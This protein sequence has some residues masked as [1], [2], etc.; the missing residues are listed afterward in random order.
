MYSKIATIIS[1]SFLGAALEKMSNKKVLVSDS[2][3]TTG[4]KIIAGQRTMSCQ[5]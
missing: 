5:N 3:V 1:S 2:H 4:L